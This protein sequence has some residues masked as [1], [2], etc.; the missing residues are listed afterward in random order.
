MKVEDGMANLWTFVM[1]SRHSRLGIYLTLILGT[2]GSYVT[3]NGFKLTHLNVKNNYFKTSFSPTTMIELYKLDLNI[4]NSGN[5][6]S[7]KVK[8]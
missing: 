2:K 4:L 5:F 8:F 6:T 7:L 3:R 1:L